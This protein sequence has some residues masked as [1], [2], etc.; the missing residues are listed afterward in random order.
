M[1]TLDKIMHNSNEQ[2]CEFLPNTETET[3]REPEIGARVTG[4]VIVWG[5]YT[6]S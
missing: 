2:K 6:L 5:T 1:N 4:Q 3:E